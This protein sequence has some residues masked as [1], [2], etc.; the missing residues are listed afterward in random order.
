MYRQLLHIIY[1]WTIGSVQLVAILE[2]NAKKL[3]W[4]TESCYFFIPRYFGFLCWVMHV[5]VHVL[6]VAVIWIHSNFL[7]L[8]SWHIGLLILKH[9]IIWNTKFSTWESAA[10]I[11]GLSNWLETAFSSWKEMGSWASGNLISCFLHHF[12]LLLLSN[13]LH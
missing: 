12:V 11:Y 2:L 1:Y 10:N 5:P 13:P 9:S 4:A 8:I 7:F 3:W 6:F